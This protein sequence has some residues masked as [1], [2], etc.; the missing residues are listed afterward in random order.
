MK[1]ILA[2]I[3]AATSGIIGAFVVRAR[4]PLSA[5]PMMQ[6]LIVVVIAALV[7]EGGT[8]VWVGA[9]NHPLQPIIAGLF[10]GAVAAYF[11]GKKIPPRDDNDSD[12][13]GKSKE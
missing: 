12:K 7:A 1:T 9:P 4:R 13:S 2:L 8:I 6:L 3:L 10:L 11:G 5:I